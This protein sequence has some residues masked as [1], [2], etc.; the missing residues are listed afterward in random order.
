[1]KK[2]FLSMLF[3]LLSFF[4]GGQTAEQPT[5]GYVIHGKFRGNYQA[6]KVYLVED[7]LT[8]TRIT[9]STEVIHNQYTFKGP[10]PTYVK[11]YFIKSAVPDSP[12]AYTS[13]FLEEGDIH[14]ESDAVYLADV[15]VSGSINNL[16][17]NYEKAR[18]SHVADSIWFE[19]R[20]LYSLQGHPDEKGELELLRQRSEI[21]NNRILTVTQELIQRFPDQ[22]YAIF[23]LYQMRNSF[24]LPVV[25]TLRAHLAP[26]LNDHPYT[27]AL[28][29]FLYAADFQV[30]HQM[31]DFNLPDEKGKII[32]LKDLKGKY[33]LIDFWA[34]WCGPCLKEMPHLV[35]LYKTC[36]GKNFEILGISMDTNRQAWL[37]AIKKQGMKWLQVCDL[38]AW[39][40]VPA[41][42]CGVKSIPHTLFLDPDGK[43]IAIGLR[44]TALEEKV[45]Q[46]IGKNK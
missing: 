41:K 24:P 32:G 15:K 17:A 13:F 43:V 16:L 40:S 11:R 46:V 27:K 22:G 45:K 12:S 5:E 28:D 35:N 20:I 26:V 25:K 37:A 14:I 33:V 10:K 38:Q 9:D 6:R 8:G 4:S 18:V 30:G 23:T 3:V 42:T 21:G 29:E 1:M 39:N 31:P 34:S 44:G 7:N 36:K 2:N 19:H